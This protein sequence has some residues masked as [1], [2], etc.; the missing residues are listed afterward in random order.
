MDRF[1]IETCH[2]IFGALVEPELPVLAA[3]RKP[4]TV[5]R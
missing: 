2:G 5:N 1:P 3:N 4:K